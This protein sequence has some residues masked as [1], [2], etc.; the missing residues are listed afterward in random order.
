MNSSGL[1]TMCVVPSR[2]GGLELEHDLPGAVDL[3]A[4]IGQ[5]RAR[6]VAAK[7][8]QP[9]ALVGAAAHRRVLRCCLDGRR[10]ALG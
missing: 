8:F 10:R 6:D 9:L 2:P 4:F 3:Y 5:C 7:L 1:I